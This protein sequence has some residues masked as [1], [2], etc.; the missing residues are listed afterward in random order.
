MPPICLARKTYFWGF[1]S[2]CVVMSMHNS[3]VPRLLIPA[4]HYLGVGEIE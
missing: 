2:V 4:K 1:L 3:I